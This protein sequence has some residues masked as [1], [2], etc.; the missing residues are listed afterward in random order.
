MEVLNP[1][2]HQRDV[3]RV[4]VLYQDPTVAVEYDATWRA[5]ANRQRVVDLRHLGKPRVLR[6]LEPPEA[7]GQHDEDGCSTDLR[8]AQQLLIPVG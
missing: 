4:P 7:P 8:C 6:D 5:K 3:Q 2:S 1:F